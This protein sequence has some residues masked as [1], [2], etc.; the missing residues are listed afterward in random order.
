[1]HLST[2]QKILIGTIGGIVAVFLISL[3]FFG[4]EPGLPKQRIELTMWG[5]ADEP[6]KIQPLLGEFAEFYRQHE[7]YENVTINVKYTQIPEETYETVLLNALAEDRGPDVFFIHNTWLPQYAS[8]LSPLPDAFMTVDLFESTFV[9]VATHDLIF[10]NSIYAL[11]LYVD[12]LAL[13]YNAAQYQDARTSLSRPQSTWLGI[14]A[15]SPALSIVNSSKELLRGSIALGTGETITYASDIFALLLRQHGGN[16]CDDSCSSVTINNNV[17]GKRASEQALKTYFSF[18]YPEN[19]AGSWNDELI[20]EDDIE[21]DIDA[22]IEGK[23]SSIIGYQEIYP[24]LLQ[25]TENSDVSVRIAE[26]PQVEDPNLTESRDAFANYWAPA[27]SVKSDNAI[28]AWQLLGFLTTSDALSKY[29][30]NTGRPT[31]RQDLI[32]LHQ[33]EPQTG[34]FATQAK[35]A[36]SINVYNIHQFREI[37][38]EVLDD[39]AEGELSIREAMGVLEDE[40]YESLQTKRFHQT[41]PPPATAPENTTSP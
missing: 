18:K 24:Q 31:S 2:A 26:I 15:D 8:K 16:V 40:L 20:E 9:P 33:A 30:T 1:M 19:E 11:P 38:A 14:Q 22:F 5:V 25:E 13:Y 41:L 7:G 21:N 32:S 28:I 34:I 17:S 23:V 27:V 6:E 12:T 36:I 37:V 4:R 3:A 10:Q 29:H 39:I 35:Y